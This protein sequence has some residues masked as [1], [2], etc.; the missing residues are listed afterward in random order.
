M[1]TQLLGASSAQMVHAPVTVPVLQRMKQERTPIVSLTAYDF[2]FARL[3]DR[4]GVDILLVGDSLGMVIQGHPTTLPVTLEQMIYHAAAVVRGAKRAMVVCDLPFGVCHGGGAAVM[5]A[6]VR[7]V[8]ES[9]C[10]AVKLEGGVRIAETIRYLVEHEVPVM[11][12][13]GLTPQAVHRMGGFKVQGRGEEGERVVADALAVQEAG[14][15]AVVLEGIPATLAEKI[16]KSLLIP[17]I[18]I[19][20]GVACDGQV[21]VMHDLLGVYEEVI[22][23]FAKRYLPEGML[24]AAVAAYVQEVRE[25]EFPGAEHSFAG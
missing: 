15:F 9:G 23:R 1:T 14:A 16:S 17:T 19:G 25:R 6:A 18:G 4:A 8:K 20:A 24:T 11:G 10:Q 7:I 13:V 3:M 12:H 5:A 2:S 21:L 22:P